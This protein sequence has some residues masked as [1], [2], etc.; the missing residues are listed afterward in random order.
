MSFCLIDDAKLRRI[1]ARCNFFCRFLLKYRRQRSRLATNGPKWLK[2]CRKVVKILC[3]ISNNWR[4]IL[5]FTRFALPLH[6]IIN[7]NR[8]DQVHQ[9]GGNMECNVARRGNPAGCGVRYHLSG[10]VLPKRQQLGPLGSHPL[11][12]R[13]AGLLRGL[14]RLPLHPSPL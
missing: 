2:N 6:P 8:N 1:L 5:Y 12:L 4:F 10:V 14:N 9:K 7:L 11:S 3:C 13:Y